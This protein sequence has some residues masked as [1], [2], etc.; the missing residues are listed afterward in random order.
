MEGRKRK[1]KIDPN[2]WQYW[3]YRFEFR[4]RASHQ[5]KRFN[6]AGMARQTSSASPSRT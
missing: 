2:D 6:P 3:G 1:G 4:E 5:V